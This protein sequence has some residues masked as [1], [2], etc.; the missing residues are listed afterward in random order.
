[1]DTLKPIVIDPRERYERP[2]ETYDVAAAEGIKAV[3]SIPLVN[4][5]PGRRTSVDFTHDR[6]SVYA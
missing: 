6:G 4:R 2:P 5:E 3:C 1:M